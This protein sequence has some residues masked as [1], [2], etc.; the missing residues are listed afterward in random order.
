MESLTRNSWGMNAPECRASIGPNNFRSHFS[1]LVTDIGPQ[2]GARHPLQFSPVG[3]ALD[4][5]VGQRAGTFA[6]LRRATLAV[7]RRDVRMESSI[8]ARTGL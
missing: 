3:D 5:C 1:L 6:T 8:S 7:P 2:W 4:Y